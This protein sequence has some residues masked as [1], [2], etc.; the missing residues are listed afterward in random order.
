MSMQLRTSVHAADM[1]LRPVR[2]AEAMR[3]SDSSQ[4]SIVLHMTCCKHQN[5]A[6]ATCMYMHACQHMLTGQGSHGR[7]YTA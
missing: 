6:T 3:A 7:T 2:T 1:Q 5:T 4:C